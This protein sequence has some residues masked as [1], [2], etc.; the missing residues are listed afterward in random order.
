MLHPYVTQ[1]QISLV[2]MVSSQA[3]ASWQHRTMLCAIAAMCQKCRDGH[4][5]HVMATHKS[6]KASVGKLLNVSKCG[7]PWI[8]L[9]Y[10]VVHAPQLAHVEQDNG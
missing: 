2:G 10:I 1:Q 9:L 8:A 5:V 6:A 4:A 7:L 3:G